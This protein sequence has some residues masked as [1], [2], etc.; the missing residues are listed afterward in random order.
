MRYCTV[1]SF[2]FIAFVSC[3]AYKNIPYFQDLSDTAKLTLIKT[4]TFKNPVIEPGDILSVTIET[5]D[6]EVTSLLNASA[7]SPHAVTGFLVN[8]DGEIQLSFIGKIKVSGFTTI[9]AEEAIAKEAEKH[10]N[11]PMVNVRFA[12]FKITVLGEVTRPGTYI[13]PTEKINLFDAIGLAG[14]L[15]PYALRDNILLIRDSLNDKALVRMNLKSKNIISSPYFYLQPNDVIYVVPAKSVI[16]KE[17]SSVIRS[18]L[19]IIATLVSLTLI[20][21]AFFLKK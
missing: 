19:Q 21:L 20:F 14:D 16:A 7:S 8:K 12:N 3:K 18:N 17:E 9:E 5:L 10:F 1:L 4:A 13:A 6:K 11:S 15:T 2:I